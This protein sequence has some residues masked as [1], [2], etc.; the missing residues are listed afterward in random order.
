MSSVPPAD[1]GPAAGPSDAP[2]QRPP[3][4]EEGR[5]WLGALGERAQRGAFRLERRVTALLSALARRRGWTPAVH[6]YAGYAAAGRVRVLARVLLVAPGVV[7]NEVTGVAG[8]RR[9]LT[10]EQPGVPIDVTLRSQ[11]S[12]DPSRHRLVSGT[13]G[14]VDATVTHDVRPGRAQALLRVGDRPPVAEVVH[15]AL[16]G[17]L[18]VVCDIDDTAWVTGLRHPLRAAWRTFARGSTGREAVPGMAD[19]LRA[20]VAGQEHPAVVYLSNGPWN[21][22]GPV[23]RFLERH[24]FPPGPL[25]M[26]EWGFRPDAWFRSGREHKAGALRRL[27]EELPR[28]RWLLVGDDGEHDPVLYGDLAREHPDRVAAV[29]VR[30][31]VPDRDAAAVARRVA[32]VPVVTGPDGRALLTALDAVL[33]PRPWAVGDADPA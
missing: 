7:P 15:A 12:D 17:G 4:G 11:D 19:L 13:G 23:A 2:A 10:L 26:T 27:L 29:A 33:G 9:L 25:L 8:W 24:G 6:S 1:P 21:L 3:G 32:G 20:A 5:G 18:G 22:A 28:T 30:Q 14:L 16:D 31:V